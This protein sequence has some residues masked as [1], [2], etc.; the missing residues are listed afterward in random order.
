MCSYATRNRLKYDYY[1][2]NIPSDMSD[3][4]EERGDLA[5]HQAREI[6]KLYCIPCDWT[7]ISDDGEMVRVRRRRR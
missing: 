4:P 1:N 2:I 3:N 5:I 7:I 6:A